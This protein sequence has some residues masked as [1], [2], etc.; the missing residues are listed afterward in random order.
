M[1]DREIVALYWA[2]EERAIAETERRYGAVL[3]HLA[4]NLLGRREDAE[5]CVS[6]AYHA[7]WRSIPPEEPQSLRAYLGRI[8]RNLAVSRWRAEHAQKRFGGMETLLSELSDCVP[9]RDNVE[10]ELETKELTALIARWLRGLDAE[11]RA[12]FLRRYWYGETVQALA[13]ECGVSPSQMA[14]RMLRLRRKLRAALEAEGV[15]V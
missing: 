11:S 6:D 15:T 5:E 4:E 2:R 3:R 8:V 13:K 7:A 12:L 14:Q 1:E 9:A 10:A